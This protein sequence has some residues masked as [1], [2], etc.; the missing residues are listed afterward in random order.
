MAAFEI[1][2]C[3]RPKTPATD[4]FVAEVRAQ[5]VDA[6]IEHLHKKFDGTGHIGVPVMALEWL[7]KELR[8]DANT[9]ELVAAG[10]ITKVGE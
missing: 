10:I 7:A 6:A 8:Q 1:L 5:G 4:A 3:K 2:C 9:A